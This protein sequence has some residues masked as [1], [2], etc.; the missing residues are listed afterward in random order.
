MDP[1]L[2]INHVLR[3]LRLDTAVFDEVRDDVNELVPSVV[4]AVVSCFLAGLGSFLYWQ[5]IPA[6]TPDNAFLNAFILGSVFMVAVYAV[7]ILVVYLVMAQVFKVQAEL[8]ALFRTM[9]YAAVPLAFSVLMF[10]PVIYPLFSLAPL[11]LL[12]VFMI[13]AVQ[14]ATNADSTHVVIASFAGFA[15]MCLLLGLIAVATSSPSV[16]AGAGQFGLFLDFS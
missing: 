12:L 11:G 2:V 16:P 3:L 6:F 4:V 5:V 7:A 9:G 13:Y 1:N 14:S 10:I 15:V 8:Y